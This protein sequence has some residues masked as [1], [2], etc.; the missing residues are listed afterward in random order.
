MA[1]NIPKHPDQDVVNAITR[2]CD[3]LCEWER[4]T[5]RQSVLIIREQGGFCYRALSGK[6]FIPDDVSD[7]DAI[8]SIGE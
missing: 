4:T 2:L 6:P 1:N 5:G 8:Q 7:A 3:A